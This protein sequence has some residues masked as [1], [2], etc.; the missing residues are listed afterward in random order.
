MVIAIKI[1]LVGYSRRMTHE[2]NL[3]DLGENSSFILFNFLVKTIKHSNS[4]KFD[5]SNTT[6]QGGLSRDRELL[7]KYSQKP[8]Y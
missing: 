3:D 4:L 6:L 7:K 1:K 2:F 5:K 8:N